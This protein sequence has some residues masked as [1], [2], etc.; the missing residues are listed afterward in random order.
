MISLFYFDHSIYYS[1]IKITN[2]YLYDRTCVSRAEEEHNNSDQIT[3]VIRTQLQ[4]EQQWKQASAGA[5]DPGEEEVRPCLGFW[6]NI[7]KHIDDETQHT[8]H[9]LTSFVAVDHFV[10]KQQLHSWLWLIFW[11][12]MALLWWRY[13]VATDCDSCSF[14]S[15]IPADLL[16][17]GVLKKESIILNFILYVHIVR[18][19]FQSLQKNLID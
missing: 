14:L 3:T 13:Q 7:R 10:C 15:F 8:A 17:Y 5:H 4:C 6:T 9:S 2:L 11:N 16:Y 18:G 1:W 12:E 19:Y